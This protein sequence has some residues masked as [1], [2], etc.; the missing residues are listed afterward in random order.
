MFAVDK[1]PDRLALAKEFGAEP[2]HGDDVD[3]AIAAVKDATDGRG[4]DCAM[5][6]VGH[7]ATVNMGFNM[8]RMGGT[9]LLPAHGR[10]CPQ[11]VEQWNPCT[12]PNQSLKASLSCLVSDQH[13]WWKSSCWGRTPPSI[14]S[15]PMYMLCTVP[16][17]IS[18]DA[19][20]ACGQ[21]GAWLVF[22][23]CRG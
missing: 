19:V 7:Q 22:A 11:A 8:L 23:A 15:T 16:L 1:V 17:T 3:S 9:S 14:A 21:S 13:F 10:L 12:T 2:I 20:G 4:V 6:A 18:D 5:E